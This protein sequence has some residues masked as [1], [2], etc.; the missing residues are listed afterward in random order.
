M[1]GGVYFE[2]FCG[3]FCPACREAGRG[4]HALVHCGSDEP[5]L[6]VLQV[7]CTNR[8]FCRHVQTRAVQARGAATGSGAERALLQA[9]SRARVFAMVAVGELLAL[10]AIAAAASALAAR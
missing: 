9:R 4:D 2:A 10:G 5:D 1:S 3:Q 8:R 7:R 6:T